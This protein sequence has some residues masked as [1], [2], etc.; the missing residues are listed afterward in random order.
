MITEID[1][2]VNINDSVEIKIDNSCKEAS[3]SC[4]IL[5]RIVHLLD[6]KLLNNAIY[7]NIIFG[8][9]FA[10]FSD[11]MFSAVLPIYMMIDKG[12]SKVRMDDFLIINLIFI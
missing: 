3:K 11:N 8:F 7:V 6:L 9:T 12:F 10:I 4:I 2:S 1:D 5:D